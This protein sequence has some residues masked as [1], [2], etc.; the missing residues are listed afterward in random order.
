MT[1]DQLF[2]GTITIISPLSGTDLQK[3]S[4]F[5]FTFTG[6]AIYAFIVLP[7][8]GYVYDGTNKF[9][10][11]GWV[12]RLDLDNEAPVVPGYASSNQTQEV[13]F[14]SSTNLNDGPHTVVLDTL[15]GPLLLDS[16][17][18]TSND[19]D[20]TSSSASSTT[21]STSGATSSTSSGS[22]A[23]LTS[24]S[25]PPV[26][27]IA[28]GVVGATAL[29]LALVVGWMFS[30]RAKRANQPT[31][32]AVEESASPSVNP[33]LLGQS[34]SIATIPP[35]KGSGSSIAQDAGSGEQ[36]RLLQEEVR[37]LRQ[38]QAG[39][40][41]AGSTARSSGAGSEP[42]SVGRSLSSMK[43]NQTRALVEHDSGLRLSAGRIVDELPPTYVAD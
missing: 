12:G 41:T 14:F 28:G 39:S 29:I 13:C 16:I 24:H 22:T 20:A 3:S 2:N 43:R 5:T 33:F 31:T 9:A 37:Q 42:M 21:S 23:V 7:P 36:V 40:S 30:R 4:G 18:Y 32:P 11:S 34:T 38:Q 17:I 6:T 8:A 26:G 10:V 19:A 15:G 27:A 25:K 1:P 35:I